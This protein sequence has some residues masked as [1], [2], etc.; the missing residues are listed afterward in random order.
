M[1]RLD[2]IRQEHAEVLQKVDEHNAANQTKEANKLKYGKANQIAERFGTVGGTAAVL[3]N[4]AN[5]RLLYQGNGSG[6]L[7]SVYA[8]GDRF[9][10]AEEKANGSQLGTRIYN[11]QKVQQGS[12][13]YL[14]SILETMKN[15][16]DPETASIGRQ[17]SKANLEGKV[18]YFVVRTQMG[19]NANGE[20][21]VKAPTIQQFDLSGTK[22]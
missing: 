18:D 22:K 16:Q 7:D 21:F 6:T 4:F 9:I 14:E 15:S 12:P 20:G 3:K 10:V 11:G 17:L 1:K 13:Q 5:A 19:T 2:A 8:N